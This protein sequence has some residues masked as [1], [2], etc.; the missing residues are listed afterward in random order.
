MVIMMT[1]QRRCIYGKPDPFPRSL[2]LLREK[3]TSF[4][5]V[6]GRFSTLNDHRTYLKPRKGKGKKKKERKKIMIKK[7]KR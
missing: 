5:K 2:N 3:K 4:A 7:K 1:K 6:N